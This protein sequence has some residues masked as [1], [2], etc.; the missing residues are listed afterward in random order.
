MNFRIICLILSLFLGSCSGSNDGFA[1]GETNLP[2]EES[3][4]SNNFRYGETVTT[5]GGWE[6]TLDTV[7]P[8]NDITLANG[9]V[10]EVKYE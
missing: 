10:V 8:I 3:T 5:S 7:D 6:A 1:P 4:S 2:P 9:W